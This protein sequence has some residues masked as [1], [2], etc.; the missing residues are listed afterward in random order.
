M[1]FLTY[2]CRSFFILTALSSF[3]CVKKTVQNYTITKTEIEP[4]NAIASVF[5]KES[6]R[7]LT[8]EF[9]GEP[10]ERPYWEE[11]R[12]LM[13]IGMYVVYLPN[14]QTLNETEA[15]AIAEIGSTLYLNGLKELNPEVMEVLRRGGVSNLHLNGLKELNPKAATKLANIGALTSLELNGLSEFTP[16]LARE[17]VKTRGGDIEF[18][19]VRQI[20]METVNILKEARKEVKRN[21][22]IF[23]IPNL[24]LTPEMAEIIPLETFSSV[25]QARS[26]ID[27]EFVS[28]IQGREHTH[29]IFSSLKDIA[30]HLLSNL[31]SKEY[32]SIYLTSLDS[33]S[34]P[35]AKA[36]FSFQ[37]R[38]ILDGVKHIDAATI[39]ELGTLS[40]LSL[41]GIQEIDEEMARALTSVVQTSLYLNGVSSLSK[42]VVDIFVQSNITSLHLQSLNH[43]DYKRLHRLNRKYDRVVWFQR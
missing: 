9:S 23:L 26:H 35:Q 27:E 40:E 28:M 24:E 19:G 3:G 1:Y 2:I 30:P 41:N 4:H 36:L 38:L 18:N 6:Q 15:Q 5:M 8:S 12:F 39:R 32:S 10:E 42:E 11:A 22:L 14:I 33:L 29:L 37:G 16:E 21:K 13:R 31:V 20:S 17:L 34:K 43:K 25:I 7:L